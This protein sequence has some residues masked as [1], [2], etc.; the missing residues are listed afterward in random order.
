MINIYLYIQGF[1]NKN[2]K[3]ASWIQVMSLAG[4]N[5]QP[6]IKSSELSVDDVNANIIST[7]K[8]ELPLQSLNIDIE[9]KQSSEL[10]VDKIK[11]FHLEQFIGANN[12]VESSDGKRSRGKVMN[13]T[14]DVTDANVIKMICSCMESD[15]IL[16]K[17]NI[18]GLVLFILYIIND[19]SSQDFSLQVGAGKLLVDI[20]ESFPNHIADKNLV[21]P[22]LACIT[23]VI[24]RC[25]DNSELFSFPEKDIKED[26]KVSI[27]VIALILIEKMSLCILPNEFIPFVVSLCCKNIQSSTASMRKAGCVII[28]LISTICSDSL[29]K[30][31][32]SFVPLIVISVADTDV[33]TIEMACFALGQFSEYFQPEI[34][35]YHSTILSALS[36]ALDNSNTEILLTACYALELTICDSLSSNILPSLD[37]LLSKVGA[38]HSHS[39]IQVQEL[40]FNTLS[41]IVLAAE[42]EILPYIPVR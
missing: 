25:P 9:Q 26:E 15:K 4:A 34:L 11:F 14:N 41:S 21:E 24:A 39:S 40:A 23:A 38:L 28:G 32:S 8:D 30:L 19:P 13:N 1:V 37:L 5:D 12:E 20:I 6:S 7:I 31:V 29:N 22:T 17:T 35:A 16:I 2:T 27:V 36:N 18:E 10:P 33:N 42:I 3:N